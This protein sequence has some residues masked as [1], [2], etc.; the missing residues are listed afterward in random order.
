MIRRERAAPEQLLLSRKLLPV[1]FNPK[2]EF[3][4]EHSSDT[5]NHGQLASHQ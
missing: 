4:Y 2:E 1:N 3:S 5:T